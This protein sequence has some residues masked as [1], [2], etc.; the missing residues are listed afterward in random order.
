MKINMINLTIQSLNVNGGEL[1]MN[2]ILL[3]L[4]VL[5]IIFPKQ[6]FMFGRGW[7]FK[8]GTEPS[9][10]IKYVGRFIGVFL[11]LLV[12]LGKF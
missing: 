8:E 1:C 5:A 2:F 10:S 3:I 4:G 9:E 11:I 12:L 7:M 6:A